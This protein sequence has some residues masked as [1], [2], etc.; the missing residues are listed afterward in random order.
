MTPE[1]GV[2]DPAAPA[3]WNIDIDVLRAAGPGTDRCITGWLDQRIA[4]AC[5]GASCRP[6]YLVPRGGISASTTSRA[7]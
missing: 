1:Q 3:L 6:S 5:S 7:A 4:T 2:L